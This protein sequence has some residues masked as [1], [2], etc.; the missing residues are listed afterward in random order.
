MNSMGI[1]PPGAM[2]HPHSSRT[3]SG[4]VPDLSRECDEAV[5]SAATIAKP[6]PSA[7][8]TVRSRFSGNGAFADDRQAIAFEA[9]DIA[10]G[11]G[12]ELH[13]MDAKV[14]EDLGADAVS[15]DRKSTRLN[16][17]H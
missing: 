11:G 2:V 14:G 3:A 1:G 6:I 7:S 8:L 5:V 9:D 10:V 13:R 12:E 16:S 15:A 4:C 17:S